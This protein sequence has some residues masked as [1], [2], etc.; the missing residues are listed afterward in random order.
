ML[1][2]VRVPV[3][4]DAVQEAV[5]LLL[6]QVLQRLPLRAVGPL[7]QQGRVPLLQQLEDQARR[8]QVPVKKPSVDARILWSFQYPNSART[9]PIDSSMAVGAEA[10][11]ASYTLHTHGCKN[12]H[13]GYP[14]L[15]A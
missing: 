6:Q 2:A 8:P 9:M 14:L 1:A 4:P 3:Q 10:A 7:R 13:L 15:Y 5:P 12:V 11:V